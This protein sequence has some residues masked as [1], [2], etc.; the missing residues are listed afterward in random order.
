MRSKPRTQVFL[1]NGI[2]NWMAF[3]EPGRFNMSD[4]F[5]MEYLRDTSGGCRVRI[6][7]PHWGPEEYEI[8]VVRKSK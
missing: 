1:E 4:D 2:K 6:T 3:C 7:D 5:H 8:T